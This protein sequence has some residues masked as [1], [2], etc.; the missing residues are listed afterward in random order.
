MNAGLSAGLAAA[1][2]AVDPVGLGGVVLRSSAGAPRERWLAQLRDLLPAD[3]PWRRVPAHIDDDRL[4][5]G[6]DLAATLQAGRPVAQRGLL[7]EAD[8]G[9]VLLAMAERLRAGTAAALAAAIDA[10]AV[11]TERQG[12]GTRQASRLGVVALDEGLADDERVPARLR[13][14]LAFHV[15][16]PASPQSQ[17]A[18]DTLFTRADV[19]A[20]RAAVGGVRIAEAFVEGLFDRREDAAAEAARQLAL[21][22]PDALAFQ[23]ETTLRAL[24]WRLGRTVALTCPEAG[25][26]QPRR[27]VLLARDVRLADDRVTLTLLG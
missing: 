13:E 5:G 12:I 15:T 9:V 11:V 25:L 23:V 10:Q 24:P 20:A 19:A 3:T 2:F 22:S 17:G 1:L 6:L 7:A 4:L 16:L 18:D 14:R 8:G 21:R 27:M 26:A